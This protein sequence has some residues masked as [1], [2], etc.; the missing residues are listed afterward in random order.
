MHKVLLAASSEYFRAMLRGYMKESKE[1]SVDLRGITAASLEMIVDFIYS[2]KMD[3]D[4]ECLIDVLNAANH[5]QIQTALDLCSD[6]IISLLTF[7]NAESL[8][9]IADTY[10]LNRVTDFYTE[11]LLTEFEEFSLSSAFLSLTS[12]HLVT[13]MSNDCLKVR[14]EATL[15]DIMMRWVNHDET[16]VEFLPQIIK[17][18]RF[19]LMSKAQLQALLQH[20]LIAK[21]PSFVGCL[22]AG[23]QYHAE[24]TAGHPRIIDAARIRTCEQSLVLIHQGS[25]LR[26]FEIV[27]YDHKN[28]RFHQLISDTN[29]CRD[30]RIASI[31]DY[32]YICRV[33]DSGGGTLIS[34]LL[35][36]DPRHLTLTMLSSGRQPRI[37]PALVACGR[38]L[39]SFGGCVDIPQGACGNTILNSVESYDVGSNLWSI[40]GSLPQ[41]THSHA[42]V[43][44]KGLIFISGGITEPSR[45]VTTDILV[46]DPATNTYSYRAPMNCAR[47]LHEMAVLGNSIYVLGGIGSHSFH[48]QTQIS[49]ECYSLDADQWTMLSVTLAGRSVGHFIAFQDGILSLGREHHQATEDDIWRYDVSTNVWETYAKAPSRTS[50]SSTFGILININFSDE[51]IAKKI[52]SERR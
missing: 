29:G 21:C 1:D 40:L 47:R 46:Y 14:S 17:C 23:L 2:G 30:C 19:A 28:L 34:S 26:P 8:V 32:I 38:R 45:V 50:L 24:S 31:D 3:L 12:A 49:I 25:S 6:Y 10:S 11:K 22:Q 48:Q 37:D 36:F 51:K 52:M 44:A 13:Y 4:L 27:A 9:Q 39:Y 16:R 41:R 43:L 35:R 15:L 18:V 5:L 42:A 33:I 20:P 7:M